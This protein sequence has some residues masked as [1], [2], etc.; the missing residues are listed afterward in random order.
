MYLIVYFVPY[1]FAEI[2]KN[3]LF[4]IGAGRI[5][6][7]RCCSNQVEVD[8]QFKGNVSC[9][10]YHGKNDI[11]N[12]TK[13]LRIEIMCEDDLLRAAI[14]ELKKFHPYEEVPYQIIKVEQGF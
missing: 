9:N 13:E 14:Q 8:S 6:K 4:S 2:T 1:E 7:Y 11:V 10:P 12:H 5:G 3:A